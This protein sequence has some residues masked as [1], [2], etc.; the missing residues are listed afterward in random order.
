MLERECNRT[1]RYVCQLQKI[2]YHDGL[3][4]SFNNFTY[5]SETET[6]IWLAANVGPFKI[7]DSDDGSDEYSY[8]YTS[9]LKEYSIP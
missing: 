2:P 3:F 1:G 9:V 6:T 5:S 8:E 7:V 4:T